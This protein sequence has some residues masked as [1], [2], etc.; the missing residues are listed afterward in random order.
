MEKFR[1]SLRGR[2]LGQSDVSTIVEAY[3]NSNLPFY[4][5]TTSLMACM[6]LDPSLAGVISEEEYNSFLTELVNDMFRSYSDGK[7]LHMKFNNADVGPTEILQNIKETVLKKEKMVIDSTGVNTNGDDGVSR[8]HEFVFRIGAKDFISSV[9]H[10]YSKMRDQELT[11]FRVIIPSPRLASAGYNETIKIRCSTES[12]P[13]MCKFLYG[14]IG[15]KFTRNLKTTLYI[16]SNS[17][18][19]LLNFNLNSDSDYGPWYGYRQ[20]FGDGTTTTSLLC[21]AVYNAIT[22]VVANECRISG[23]VK[24]ENDLTAQEYLLNSK[25]RYVATRKL[26]NFFSKEKDLIPAIFELTKQ[27]IAHISLLNPEYPFTSSFY[28]AEMDKLVASE[29]EEKT[30]ETQSVGQTTQIKEKRRIIGRAKEKENYS[31]QYEKDR[32]TL[33]NRMSELEEKIRSNPL[34]PDDLKEET[35]FSKIVDSLVLFGLGENFTVG[36]SVDNQE[37]LEELNYMVDTYNTMNFLMAGTGRRAEL[38]LIKFVSKMESSEIEEKDDLIQEEQKSSEEEKPIETENNQ[39]EKVSVE[40]ETKVESHFVQH[41][42]DVARADDFLDEYVEVDSQP[43]IDVKLGNLEAKAIFENR[44]KELEEVIRS[45]NLHPFN[46]GRKI[47]LQDLKALQ[48][49]ITQELQNIAAS[50]KNNQSGG[51]RG[52]YESIIAYLAELNSGSVSKES[53]DKIKSFI[54]LNIINKRN[55]P[56]PINIFKYP[57]YYNDVNNLK[58]MLEYRLEELKSG[59]EES[60][61]ASSTE[62]YSQ[63]ESN[64]SAIVR[65]VTKFAAMLNFEHSL[66]GL[67]QEEC[68]KKITEFVNDNILTEEQKKEETM[69]AQ[70]SIDSLKNDDDAIELPKINS[71][72]SPDKTE[73]L[74]VTVEKVKEALAAN[75]DVK[76]NREPVRLSDSDVCLDYSTA[77]GL[78]IPDLSRCIGQTLRENLESWGYEI[79]PDTGFKIAA[80]FGLNDYKGTPEDERKLLDILKHLGD[81]DMYGNR[82]TPVENKVAEVDLNNIPKVQDYEEEKLKYSE[83]VP[84]TSY[85]DEKVKGTNYTVLDY[86][87]FFDLSAYFKP[88]SIL[89]L[90]EESKEVT[91]V[92]FAD[93][94]VAYLTYY[95]PDKLDDLIGCYVES[96]KDEKE[97]KVTR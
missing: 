66:E 31:S 67:S 59:L 52:D 56:N 64:L 78:K 30:V 37:K 94:L 41:F 65:V 88:N 10:L 17:Y 8:P 91:G 74:D 38:A 40:D 60:D 4:N 48:E 63:R 39:E 92:R 43:K 79:E 51:E 42:R 23:N 2:A 15:G 22:E 26:Y 1:E 5:E 93:E 76:V 80:H 57:D 20:V 73:V 70:T 85:L 97:T 96:I 33:E 72:V 83:Y 71:F 12:L 89:V 29:K 16:Y 44:K 77:D 9:N 3:A 69:S 46:D 58:A 45:N 28:D 54:Q 62:D 24:M 50:E 90:H 35:D 32:A 75:N 13:T 84:E 82:I 11:D 47:E 55:H 81:Y 95:G 53:I 49:T 6:E 14:N 25:N 7:E 87:A 61:V 68:D 27:N 21:G 36:S 86:F 19:D 34:L 18:D